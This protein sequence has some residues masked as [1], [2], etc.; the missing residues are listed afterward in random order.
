M[1][2]KADI[3]EFIAARSLCVIATVSG[4]GRP[5]SAVVGFCPTDNLEIIFRTSVKSR[6]AANIQH[7][8]EVAVVIGWDGPATVQLEGT[9]R[10]L[11]RGDAKHFAEIYFSKNPAARKFESDPDSRFFLVTPRWVRHTDLSTHPWAISELDPTD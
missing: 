9:A 11:D 7:T 8:P 2:S 1:K 6:K 5:E 3:A 4:E 10:Q